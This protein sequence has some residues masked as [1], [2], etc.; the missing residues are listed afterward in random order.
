MKQIQKIITALI[1]TIG[2]FAM[3]PMTVTASYNPCAFLTSPEW[4]P[5]VPKTILANGVY[6]TTPT[7]IGAWYTYSGAWYQNP[8]CDSN[9]YQYH[10]PEQT[11]IPTATPSPTPSP[12][13]TLTPISTPT[14]L[15]I[16]TPS[17]SPVP[18]P[19]PTIKIVCDSNH[20]LY[21]GICKPISKGGFFYL[22]GNSDCSRFNILNTMLINA[23][24]IQEYNRYLYYQDMM[25]QDNGKG[26]I[27]DM[28]NYCNNTVVSKFTWKP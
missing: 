17:P 11:P 26:T 20:V 16:V 8:S 14:P 22:Y 10:I 2:I 9:T 18:T 7:E 19:K 15:P 12:I 27:K 3:Y 23:T 5:V 25:T 24:S 13:P 28:K 4:H 1:L 21:D 6:Y